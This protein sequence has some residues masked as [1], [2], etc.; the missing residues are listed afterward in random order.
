MN[1]ETW[2]PVYDRVL[3]AFGYGPNGDKKARDRLADLY[4]ETG[5]S[6][7][8]TL[9]TL[10]FAGETVAVTGG[11]ESLKDDLD[12]VEQASSVVA[13][14]AAARSLREEGF[15]VDCMVTDLDGAPET[16][17]TLTSNGVPV[18]V[19]AHG[20]N[21][22]ALEAHFPDFDSTAVIPTTQARPTETV[23][24]FGGFTDGDRAAFLADQ[25]GATEVVFPGWEF[26]DKTVRPE[27]RQKLA[28]A[29]RLLHWLE[30]RRDERFTV[31]DGRRD[32]IDISPFG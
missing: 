19:H 31:L 9:S 28:W 21:I 3:E 1:F 10:E 24:N 4:L 7:E 20:D 2:E 17:K 23:R 22:P 26:D 11:A 6:V 8:E 32:D 15:A 5:N 14:S 27:K 25:L 29:A 30:H 16:A 18:A 12:M 13:A